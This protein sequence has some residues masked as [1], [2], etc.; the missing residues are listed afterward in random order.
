MLLSCHAERGEE[1]LMIKDE[2][3]RCARDDNS[4]F[5]IRGQLRVWEVRILFVPLQLGHR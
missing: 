4:H 5:D 3:L 2:F 1:S